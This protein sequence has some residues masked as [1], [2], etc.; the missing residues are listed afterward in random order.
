[1]SPAPLSCCLA[2]TPEASEGAFVWAA[3]YLE[4]CCRA[5]LHRLCLAGHRPQGTKDE[6][7]LQRLIE[8]ALASRDDLRFVPTEAGRRRHASEIVVRPDPLARS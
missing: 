1:M 4:T 6:G 8:L 3:P 2:N 5:A 7:C